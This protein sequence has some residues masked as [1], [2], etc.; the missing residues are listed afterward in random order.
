MIALV[1]SCLPC[2]GI[3]GWWWDE[4]RACCLLDVVLQAVEEVD[5][6]G[7]QYREDCVGVSEPALYA[8]SNRYRVL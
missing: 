4:Q 1:V 2:V 8:H 6:R 3:V 7:T 5:D